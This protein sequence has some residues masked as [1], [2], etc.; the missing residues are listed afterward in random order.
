VRDREHDEL[1][2]ENRVDDDVGVMPHLRA[3]NLERSLDARPARSRLRKYLD[4]AKDSSHSFFQIDAA[5]GA[6]DLV[7]G[8]RATKLVTRRRVISRSLHRRASLSSARSSL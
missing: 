7:V 5:T 8:Y 2:F 6:L 1:I 3:T 4:A